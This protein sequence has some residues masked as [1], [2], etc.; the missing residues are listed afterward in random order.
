MIDM[1]RKRLAIKKPGDELL[2]LMARKKPTQ[3]LCGRYKGTTLLGGPAGA[4]C[5]KRVHKTGILRLSN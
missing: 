5:E 2:H 1:P 4:T 3:S